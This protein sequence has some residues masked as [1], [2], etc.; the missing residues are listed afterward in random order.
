[1]IK[2]QNHDLG[3]TSYFKYLGLNIY[4]KL[5]WKVHT[6]YVK[7]KAFQ[8]VMISSFAKNKFGLK[9][10]A[11]EIIYKG[12]VIPIISYACPIWILSYTKSYINLSFERI[13]R[14]IALRLCKAYKT[15]STDAL[16]VIANL[17]PIDLTLKQRAAKFFIKKGFKNELN[18]HGYGLNYDKVQ[19]PFKYY[20]LPHSANTTLVNMA[21]VQMGN[22]MTF[23]SGIKS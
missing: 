15:V 20:D 6:N 16:N 23:T 9:S 13:Q 18:L 8:L 7:T 21:E 22:Q 10:R 14:L 2:F 19:K 1:M 11:L 17:M 12:D 4:S 3:I 5:N